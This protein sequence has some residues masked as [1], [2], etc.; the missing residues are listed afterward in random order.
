LTGTTAEVLPV[1]EVAGIMKKAAPGP[2]TKKLMLAYK[3]LIAEKH[4]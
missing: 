4:D 2:V 1:R 3:E